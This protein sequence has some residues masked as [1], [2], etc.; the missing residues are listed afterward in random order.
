M[1]QALGI[2]ALQKVGDLLAIAWSDGRE[3][4]LDLRTVRDACPCASCHGEPDVAGR[5]G[6]RTCDARKAPCG[7]NGWQFVGGYGWQPLWED[8]HAS[9][10]YTFAFLRQLGGASS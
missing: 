7:L 10:I 1:D 8:G 9:G 2:S 4:Y 6:L 3:D 5:P